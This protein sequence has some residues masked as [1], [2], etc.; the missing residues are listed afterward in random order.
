MNY[1][2]TQPERGYYQQLNSNIFLPSLTD[3]TTWPFQN[4]SVI[5]EVT[6]WYIKQLKKLTFSLTYTHKNSS[7]LDKL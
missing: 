6:E 3:F 7:S 1:T 5:H 4:S 2:L